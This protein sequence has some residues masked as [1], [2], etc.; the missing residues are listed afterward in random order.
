M[1]NGRRQAAEPATAVGY[2]RVSTAEQAE[3]G[4][5]LDAQRATVEAECARR[6]WRLVQV[7]TD[8]GVSG[9]STDNRPA[10]TEALAAVENGAAAALVVAKLDRLSRSV[11]DAAGL[12]DRAQRHGW[13]L[14]A[15]PKS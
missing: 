3:S 8:A 10:L 5:G 11:Q 4:A 6:G 7:F 9:K 13:A 15:A 14:V 1:R 2:L 12:L